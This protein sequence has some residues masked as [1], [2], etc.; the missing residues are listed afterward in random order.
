[1][2][3]IQRS[4]R[5]RRVSTVFMKSNYIER[6]EYCVVVISEAKIKQGNQYKSATPKVRIRVK[7]SY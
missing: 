7:K 3:K 1:M 2:S 5:A 4:S 6:T